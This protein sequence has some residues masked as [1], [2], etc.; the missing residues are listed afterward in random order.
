LSEYHNP[1][2]QDPGSQKNLVLI[3]I[4]TFVVIILSQQFFFK[5]AEQ[6]PATE[7]PVTEQQAPAAAPATA[8]PVPAPSKPGAVPT[9]QATTETETVVE[10]SLYRITFT[11]KGGFVKSWILKKYKDS[12]GH[13][14]DLVNQA[15]AIVHGYPLSFFAWDQSLK[16]KLNSAMY[17]TSAGS[18]LTAPA[19]LTYEYSDGDLV[20][21]KTFKFDDTYTIG[22]ETSVA[23]NGAYVTALPSWPSTFGDMTTPSAYTLQRVIYDNGS[24]IERLVPKKVS[25]GAVYNGT[26]SWGGVED[27]YFAAIFL[28]QTPQSTLVELHFPIEIP[29]DPAK[30]DP[31]D[32]YKLSV[33]GA[34][35]GDMSGPT[36]LRLFVGPKAIDVLE[37]VHPIAGG[38]LRGVVDFGMFSFIARPLFM[39]LRWTH[40]HWVSNWGWSILILT[41]IINA[42]LLPLRVMSMR[43]ALKMQKIAP[44]IQSI[45]EKY[46]KYSLKDPRRAGANQEI[47]ALYK[48]H[49]VNPAGGCL[50]LIIQMPFLFAFWAMLS[51]AIELRGAHWL[52]LKDLSQPDHLYIIP[53]TIIVSTLLMQK[54]TPQAGMNPE[55]A[56]MM[57]LMMPLMLGFMSWSVASG[58]GVYWLTGTIVGIIQQLAMN[59][60]SLG[61]EIRA[62]QEKRAR[63][64]ERKK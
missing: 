11:N 10:N 22:V 31:K 57:N 16:E 40:D 45:N 38:D 53:I 39:W 54:M 23:R 13:P 62:I 43:S 61:K 37:S 56:R 30:P 3:F 28:P 5:K 63:K 48:E 46:K 2:Q 21:R 60:T 42:A 55:Q 18:Q 17:V 44:Q 64:Q 49:N 51:A 34:A 27:Q 36:D 4:L 26:M 52:W 25:G 59:R 1:Q 19:A 35:S 20:V 32:A 24:K 41:V 33:L 29:K 9:M 7:K 8:I 14:L 15:A 47:S 12:Q 58:L 6:P 50:P